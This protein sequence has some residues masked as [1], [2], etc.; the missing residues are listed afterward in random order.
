MLDLYLGFLGMLAAMAGVF[1]GAY[2]LF[3]RVPRWVAHVAATLSV[4]GLWLFHRYVLDGVFVTK[5]LPFS[6]V[7]VLGNA[8]PLF[9]AFLAGLA[10]ARIEGT[11]L[12]KAFSVVPLLAV[13]CYALV[14][15]LSGSAPKARDRWQKGVCLQTS[16]QSCGAACAATLLKAHGIEAN[17]AEMIEACVTRDRGTLNHGLFRGLKRKTAGTA[18]DAQMFSGTLDDL[19][20]LDGEPAILI[21][22]LQKGADVDPRY[23]QEWGWLPGVRHSVVFYG[24]NED[25]R[26]EMGDPAIGREYWHAGAL[27]VLWQG[28]ALRLRRR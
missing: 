11:R 19:R 12:R 24:F 28:Q 22:E 21:V 8:L 4:L 15:P 23:E 20:A 16:Y 26:I 9:G 1:A 6:N 3:K 18:W 25:G 10:W 27:E 17:E 2:A 5:L 7:M 14:R 13:A